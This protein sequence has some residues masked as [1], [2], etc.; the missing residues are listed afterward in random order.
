VIV[1]DFEQWAAMQGASRQDIGDAG[2]HRNTRADSPRV[3]NRK[4][5]QQAVKDAALVERRVAL[6]EQYRQ[7]LASGELR[8]MTK[9]ERLEFTAAGHPDNP[10]VQAARRLL[11]KRFP[12]KSM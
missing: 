12:Q 2:L 8:E 4:L 5:K 6:R 10:N 11:E 7:L 3:W 1:R 9:F